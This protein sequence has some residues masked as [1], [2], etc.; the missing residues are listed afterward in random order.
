MRGCR[1][2]GNGSPLKDLNGR[3]KV[4][5]THLHVHT[6]YSLLDASSK[7]KELT[8]RAKELGMDSLAITDHGVMYGVIDFYRAARE[9]GIKPIIGCEIYVAPGSRFDR[10]AGSGEDRYY[11]M[12]L[13]AE[14]NTGYQNLMKIVSKGFVEGFYYKPRVDDEVLRTY[15][16]GIIALSACLAGEIP[17]YLSR[18]MYEEA[19]KSA[20]KYRDTLKTLAVKTDDRYTYLVLGIENQSHVHYA[21]PVRNMLYDAM[22]LEKQVRDLASQYRKEGKNGTSEEYLS[23]MRK[24]DRLSPVITLVINFGGKK[25]DAPLSLREMYGEQPEKVLPFIQDYRVFMIDPMEMSDNDLQK[26]NSSLREVL[27]YIKYQ[28]DKARMEKLLNEDSKF[29]CLETNAALVINAMTNAGIAIDP[30]KEVVNMC[31]AIR[32]MVDE[33]IMLGEKQRALDIARR[34]I[35]MKYSKEQIVDITK[36]TKQEVEELSRTIKS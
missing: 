18:G 14:N 16:E 13:L 23:G 10:E 35:E 4:A 1:F 7:I 20:Q 36:L 3:K 31:E 8:A 9:N 22:Q 21:M 34:M 33:G 11:H 24:E 6:E 28:R 29:S 17:R 32:Q 15:H 30:N 5:F 25:W 26:L 2:A 27:A 12:I 19:C